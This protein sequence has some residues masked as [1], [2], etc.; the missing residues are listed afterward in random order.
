MRPLDYAKILS[1]AARVEWSRRR[2]MAAVPYKLEFIVTFQCGSR[3]RTCNIWQRYIDAPEKRALELSADELIRT[4]ASARKYVRWLSLTGGEVTDREDFGDIA[5]GMLGAVG[6]R[7]ALFQITTNGI[8]PERVAAVLPEVVA[9]SRGIPTYITM[10]LDGLGKTYQRV[11]GVP[12][13][14][15]R[16]KRS[17]AILEELEREE[18]HLTTG[19]Q[20][21]LSDLNV[22]QAN[23]LFEE[24]SRG[25][26]RP[27]LTL[28]TDSL[29]LTRGRLDVDARNSPRVQEAAARLW[30]RYPLKQLNDLPPTLHLGLTQRFF[31]T[32]RAP[33]DCTAGFA[34]VT[35]DPYG[36]VL[37]CDVRDT[38]LAHL[39]DHAFDLVALCTSDAWARA[40]APYRRCRDCWTPCQA[41]PT[42]MHQPLRALSLYAAERAR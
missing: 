2:G 21:T 9:A 26:E 6:D 41:Y 7:L 5:A 12:D 18:P 39:K 8:D 24:A 37:Q 32:G 35:I 40:I 1:S 16:V 29:Q 14:Y 13:G 28:A 11:R 30:R 10:S 3:C 4:A 31:R 38:P 17:M 22:D 42:L 15:A 36:G 33:M 20:V 27:I 34:T 19:W 25:K 23:E